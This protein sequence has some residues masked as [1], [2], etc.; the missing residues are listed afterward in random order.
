LHMEKS[1]KIIVEIDIWISSI[2][3]MKIF[4]KFRS[5]KNSNITLTCLAPFCSHANAGL[6]SDDL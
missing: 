3:P 5:A 4:C 2:N 6:W 1:L